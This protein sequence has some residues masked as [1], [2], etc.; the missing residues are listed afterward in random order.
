MNSFK[1]IKNVLLLI[2]ILAIAISAIFLKIQQDKKKNAEKDQSGVPTDQSQDNIIKTGNTGEIKKFASYDEAKEFVE[3]QSANSGNYSTMV[4]GL[5]MRSAMNESTGAAVP[6]MAVSDAVAPAVSAT[7]DFSKTNVQVAGVD[8]ADIVK[9]D[10]NYIYA[11]SYNTLFIIKAYPGEASE[12]V[13]KVEFKSRPTDL[14]ISG[15]NLAVFGYDNQI[16]TMDLYRSFRRQ[17]QYTFFKVFDISDKQNPK[18]VRDLN[19]EGSYFNSRLIGDYVYFVTNNY[20]Y[21]VGS[22]PV[23]PRV[24]DS[25]VALSEKCG[26]DD[27]KCFAPNIYYFD[28]PYDAFN[29]TTISAINIKDN[30]TRI[31]GDVYL[32]SGAQNMFVSPENL[33]ITY[34]KYLNEYDLEMQVSRE[35]LYPRLS[36]KERAKITKIEEV[37]DDILSPSEKKSKVQQVLDKYL[38]SLTADEQAAYDKE[39]AEKMKQK[40]NELAKEMEKTII[41]KIAISGS[42]LQYKSS[43]EVVGSVLNQFAMDE[44]DGYFR[45]ATTKNTTWSRFEEQNRPSYN[46]LYVLDA[47]MKTVGSL[48]NLA[49]GERIYS[50][51]FMGNRAY[52]V[53]YKQVDP[54]FAIDL[55]DP[56]NPRVLGQLK[57]PGFSTYLHPYDENTLIGFGK[58]TGENES[59]NTITKGLKIS[60]FDVSDVSAPKE[61][62]KYLMGD[63]GSD[64]IALYDHKAFLFS[65][66]KD[67]LALPVSLR[68][69][70]GANQWGEINFSGAMIFSLKD[71]KINY[72]GKIDHSDGGKAANTDYFDGVNYY[73]NSVKRSLYIGDNLYTLS[74]NY[75]KVN[76]LSDL[77]ELK[78]IELKPESGSN[79]DIKVIK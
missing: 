65:R 63:M 77:K 76:A 15:D 8:E 72:S 16:Y 51:R 43:G 56:R 12:I 62:D 58:D 10:G 45:I 31:T 49:E 20:N 39:L 36:D 19:F 50:V 79:T 22:D 34:T 66:E 4:K 3:S 30:S 2:L 55:A 7:P 42:S 38:S 53:T 21:S 60:L 70:T 9:T 52:L 14:Y 33:Y 64:S 6:I 46:N 37:S 78:K 5:G 59:G 54:L 24:L 57:V 71:K 11:V 23:V 26:G 13:S 28:I 67:L 17:N 40:Y 27:L 25:G 44:S 35:L 29:F 75:L 47:D 18:Q 74:N 1:K 41:H 48:E 69:S 61:L 32:L 68:K 73:D